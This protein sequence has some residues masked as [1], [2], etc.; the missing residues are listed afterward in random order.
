MKDVTPQ[1]AGRFDGGQLAT[2][3]RAALA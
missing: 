3:V 1:V 2:M